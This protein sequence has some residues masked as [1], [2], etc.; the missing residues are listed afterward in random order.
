MLVPPDKSLYQFLELIGRQIK[1]I[2]IRLFRFYDH[3]A[4]FGP[5]CIV[6]TDD[7]SC[8]FW[9]ADFC[10][11]GLRKCGAEFLNIHLDLKALGP[12]SYP[13]DV[14]FVFYPDA[15]HL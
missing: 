8:F 12:N 13:S 6:S 11:G 2:P 4:L 1:D 5:P 7:K 9:R 15:H 14:Q 10:F 3:R